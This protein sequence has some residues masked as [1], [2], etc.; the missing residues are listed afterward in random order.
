MLCYREY[1]CT[2]SK[3]GAPVGEGIGSASSWESKYRYRQGQRECPECGKAGSII[4][5]KDE[6]GGGWLCFKKKDGCGAKFADGDPAIESQQ[7]EK[8]ANPD[9]A[10]IFNVVQKMAQK[11][12]YVAATLTATGL[13]GR[14]TQDLEDMPT[15][16][17][18]PERKQQAK[19]NGKPAPEPE[20]T[21]REAMLAAMTNQ[22]SIIAT[23]AQL[24]GKMVLLSPLGEKEFKRIL[25]AHC[26]C[27]D[28]AAIKGVR[29]G[30]IKAAAA[31]MW[32]AIVHAEVFM[33][34]DAA[35]ED[36]G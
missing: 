34:T 20:L 12:A 5:G 35:P 19:A 4:K 11:R 7:V 28:A 31:E 17:A 1:R 22:G 26:A 25:F 33:G 6:Y 29:L 18:P 15:P 36:R 16:P 2:L 23:F 21:P 24:K 30:D 27:E 3:D 10:D 14:F 32:D 8:V 9:V 13:S